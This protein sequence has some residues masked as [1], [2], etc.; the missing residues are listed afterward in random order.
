MDEGLELERWMLQ[1]RDL[2]VRAEIEAAAAGL[3]AGTRLVIFG[4]GP[5]VPRSLPSAALLDF[6]A[7]LLVGATADGT[8]T[9]YHAIGLRTALPTK[10]AD[11]V[12]VTSRLGGLW[13][14]YGSQIMREA[15]RVGQRVV[16]TTRP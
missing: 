11:V 4:C 16:L 5:S 14:R 13:P 9:G 1:A 15:G 8:H 6:D 3:A 2:D 7:D 12:I 10:S